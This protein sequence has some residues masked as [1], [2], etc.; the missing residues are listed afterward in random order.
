[1]PE[2]ASGAAPRARTTYNS[3]QP[4][5]PKMRIPEV[6]LKLSRR[7]VAPSPV[8]RTKIGSVEQVFLAF[9][10]ETHADRKQS[11]AKGYYD[12][13]ALYSNCAPEDQDARIVQIG[14]AIGSLG[15]VHL[16]KE[17]LVKPRENYAIEEAASAAHSITND[18]ANEEGACIE[19]VLEEFM[20]DALE[21]A[22]KGGRLVGFHLA[23]H[24]GVIERELARCRKTALQKQW[25]AMLRSGLCVMD[26]LVGRWLQ[27]SYDRDCSSKTSDNSLSLKEVLR[28]LLPEHIATPL[29]GHTAVEKAALCLKIAR[30]LHELAVPPC[31]RPGG[32]HKFKKIFSSGMRDNGEFSETCSECGYTL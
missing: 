6:F 24:G 9:S 32:R 31:R 7:F 21:L 22:V 23:F 11:E 12:S 29:R 17:R 8:V 30:A 27:E 14:W 18:I 5:R 26:P 1:M 2:E 25:G 13:F 20:A 3:P 19:D 4:K 28:L 16:A 15:N 10:I